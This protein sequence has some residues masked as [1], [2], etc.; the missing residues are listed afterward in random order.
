MQ[1]G[2]RLWIFTGLVAL[3]LFAG[4]ELAGGGLAGTAWRAS[5][6]E[7][8]SLGEFGEPGE[9][10]EPGEPGELELPNEREARGESEAYSAKELASYALGRS[11]A[12]LIIDEGFDVDEAMLIRGAADAL[13]GREP[14][15]D[16]NRLVRALALLH[17][18]RDRR[19]RQEE[20]EYNLRHANAFLEANKEREGVYVTESG[21]QY[22]IIRPG[23]GRSP[24]S[25]DVVKV[26]YHGMFT[27][28][29][30]FDSSY[31][32]G[33]PS[34]FGV[35]EVIPGWAEALQLMQEGA[36]WRI[37]VPPHLAYGEEGAGPIGP[38]ELVIF[39]IE[40]IEIED[41]Y[42]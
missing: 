5:A 33:V 7:A 28:G 6:D 34:T 24:R 25:W 30:E 11:I 2:L 18:E 1:R 8:E 39:T 12:A 3:G 15:F 9:L 4:G 36:A 41:D 32:R 40:L 27:D 29:A 35:W 37:Y 17:E 10:R 26:H 38:N 13:N 23:T 31:R 21:L 42:Y 19:L 22:E 14:L 16:Q 20:A